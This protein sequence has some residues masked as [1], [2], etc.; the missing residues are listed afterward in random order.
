[1][2]RRPC[3]WKLINR[4]KAEL[5]SRHVVLALRLWSIME[6]KIGLESG[7]AVSA[8][9]ATGGASYDNGWRFIFCFETITI[10]VKTFDSNFLQ[11]N[12]ILIYFPIFCFF[13]DESFWV[14]AYCKDFVVSVSKHSN[15]SY[16][17]SSFLFSYDVFRS[18]FTLFLYPMI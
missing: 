18:S 9:I 8:A 2:K 11:T 10:H 4:F 15:I 5:G 17:E 1:M 13:F 3:I 12:N 7:I 6:A 16:F 14:L